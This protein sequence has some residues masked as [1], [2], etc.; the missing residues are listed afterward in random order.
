MSQEVQKK[1]MQGV[2]HITKPHDYYGLKIADKPIFGFEGAEKMGFVPVPS[3]G[4]TKPIIYMQDRVGMSRDAKMMI[5]CMP[6]DQWE[7][8][9]FA[10][11]E[12][13]NKFEDTLAFREKEGITTD[14]VLL[15]GLQYFM[16]GMLRYSNF[17]FIIDFNELNRLSLKETTQALKDL[18]ILNAGA[19][20]NLNWAI[21]KRSN[22]S[23]VCPTLARKQFF[24][25][26]NLTNPPAYTAD[27]G[28]F[29]MQ[30]YVYLRDDVLSKQSSRPW[31]DELFE[32]T[33]TEK[34]LI[35]EFDSV[36]NQCKQS[37]MQK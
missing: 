29:Y 23:N 13:A 32:T 36:K 33:I 27:D 30:R 19:T 22:L 1:M 3:K 14:R 8:I 16:L 34:Q 17:N 21:I 7:Y 2:V 15:L 26:M 18:F 11:F 35:A 31:E 37:A 10:Q 25:A 28:E 24:E 20:Q 9:R 4:L 12:M 6:R 5:D